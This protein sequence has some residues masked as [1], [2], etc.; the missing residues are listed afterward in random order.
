MSFVI[1]SRGNSPRL[2]GVQRYGN[3]RLAADER[4]DPVTATAV[5]VVFQKRRSSLSRRVDVGRAC[6][7]SF[8]SRLPAGILRSDPESNS[9]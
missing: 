3:G 5:T 9:G 2:L 8:S 1:V 7:C 4:A 6:V